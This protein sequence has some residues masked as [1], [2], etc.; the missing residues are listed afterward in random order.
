MSCGHG[1]P[2]GPSA[3]IPQTAPRAG[4]TA[5][6]D[7]MRRGIEEGDTKAEN[8]SELSPDATGVHHRGEDGTAVTGAPTKAGTCRSRYRHVLMPMKMTK[9][10]TAVMRA[11]STAAAFARN[12]I[13]PFLPVAERRHPDLHRIEARFSMASSCLAGPVEFALAYPSLPAKLCDGPPAALRRA[14]SSG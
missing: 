11:R 9:T 2:T 7:P 8:R 1:R 10:T 13:M 5:P 14:R 4:R 3:P 12:G 6:L